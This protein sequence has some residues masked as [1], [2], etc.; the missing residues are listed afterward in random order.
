MSA[1]EQSIKNIPAVG[2][3]NQMFP[4]A[5]YMP[6]LESS[7]TGFTTP[8]NETVISKPSNEQ[9]LDNPNMIFQPKSLQ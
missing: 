3:N 6:T 9:T 8:H 4:F 2:A 1:A 7:A 5:A